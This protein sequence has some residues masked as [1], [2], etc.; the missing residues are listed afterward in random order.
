MP[1]VTPKIRLP[2]TVANDSIVMIEQDTIDE[3][4]QCVYVILATEYGSRIEDPEFGIR[5]QAHR[6]GGADEGQLRAAIETYEERVRELG[7][8]EEWNDIKQRVGV[9]IS[10]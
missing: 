8:N 4:A 2:F 9:M 3:V 7:F 10:G 1:I 6:K 5:D